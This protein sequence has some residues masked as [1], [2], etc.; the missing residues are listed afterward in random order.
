[1]TRTADG[2]AEGGG[3]KCHRCGNVPTRS[4][5]YHEITAYQLG[6]SGALTL[7]KRTDRILCTPCIHLLKDGVAEPHTESLFAERNTL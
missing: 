3:I 7:R 4:T 6:N 2:Y 1:M 5:A